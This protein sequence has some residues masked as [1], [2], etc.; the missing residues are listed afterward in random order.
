MTGLVL[1]VSLVAV[2]CSKD[3]SQGGAAPTGPPVVVGLINQQDAPTGSFPE[4]RSAAL[5]AVAYVNGSLG[6]IK[7]RPLRL[8]VCTTVGTP[9]SS[10]GCATKLLASKPVAVLG[11][12]DLGAVASLP[13]LKKAEVAYVG[14]APA[15]GDE[16]T[17]QDAYLLTGG[18]A[19]DLLG[20]V[21]YAFETLKAKRVGALYVDLPGVLSTVVA[22][23]P[24][25][26]KARGATAVKLV[27]EKADT[28]DF[29]P[30]LRSLQ[31]FDPDVILVVFG[32]QS[33][34]R[35]MTARQSL[36]LDAAMFYPGACASADVVT[37]AGP[38]AEGAYFA[39]GFL[40][41]D[42]PSEEVAVWR[43]RSKGR[44]SL[45]QAGFASV[46]NIHA[47][48]EG[49]KGEVTAKAVADRLSVANQEKN[50]MANPYTCDGRQVP[51]LIAVCNA[52]VRILRYSDGSFGDVGGRWINGGD[53]LK[54][55]G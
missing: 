46:M 12:V 28:A 48:A 17:A 53:V 41:F 3:Q 55:G 45:G 21:T 24:T 19:A 37:A 49:L 2:A 7:G 6:G 32:A 35:I 4:V 30:A 31:A 16:L 38:G 1:L 36:G 51:F 44:S 50:F 26:L 9:E 10:Q 22:A 18:A 39:S 11:G 42:D 8:D 40:S 34:A 25:V 54:I 33:C 20:S 14:G 29:T 5:D 52:S 43:Q 15:L 23:A 27:A 47:L 13:I